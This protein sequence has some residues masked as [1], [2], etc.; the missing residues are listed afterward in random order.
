MIVIPAIDLR[1]GRVVRLEQGDYSRETAY[2]RD[3]V[4]LALGFQNAGASLLHIVDL[5][6]ARSGEQANLAVIREICRQVTIPVQTGGG[7]RSETDLQKRLDAGVSRVVVGSLCVEDTDQV[8]RWLNGTYR[9]RIVAGLDV[10]KGTD[11]GWLPR[12]SGW[13]R[14][15]RQDLFSLSHRLIQAGLQHLLCTDIERDGMFTGPNLGLYRELVE[16][17]P[18]LR[19]QASGGIRSRGDL[20]RVSATGAAGVIVGRA[21][22]EGR[23]ELDE[24]D[25]WSP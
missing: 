3:P 19:V 10:V 15:G 16:I 8:C 5:D 1:G 13:T 18:G 25:R 11:G 17:H 12:T 14:Q 21:L 20:V 24:I 6:G 7:V 4:E 22:L 9:E 2:A 23:I